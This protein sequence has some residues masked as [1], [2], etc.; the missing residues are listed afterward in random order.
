M[1]QTN[2]NIKDKGGA[3]YNFQSTNS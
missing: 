2:T 3:R 1:R